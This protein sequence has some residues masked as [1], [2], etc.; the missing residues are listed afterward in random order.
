MSQYVVDSRE[1]TDAW[2]NI[3]CLLFPVFQKLS[4]IY[5]INTTNVEKVR[6]HNIWFKDSTITTLSYYKGIEMVDS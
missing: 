3:N 5:S 2:F 6:N 1:S 4:Y